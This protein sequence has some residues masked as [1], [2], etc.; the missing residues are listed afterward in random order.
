M[1][2]KKTELYVARILQ[3]GVTISGLLIL[4]GLGLFL[5]TGDTCYPNGEPTLKWILWGDPFFAPSHIL[6]L[7]FILLVTTPLTRVA[8]SIMAYAIE[9]DWIY[10]AITGFVL[11]VLIIGMSLGLG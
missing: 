10:T 2:V 3:F 8:A 11:V 7:G 1:S 6:F 4:F 5:W 9:S